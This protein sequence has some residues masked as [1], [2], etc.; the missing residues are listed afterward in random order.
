[1]DVVVVA[2]GGAAATSGDILGRL[3]SG[4]FGRDG[5]ACCCC[6][7]GFVSFGGVVGLVMPLSYSYG[8][9]MLNAWMKEE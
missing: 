4:E 2:A 8:N 1:V 6:W 7:V 5:G 9:G 3:V